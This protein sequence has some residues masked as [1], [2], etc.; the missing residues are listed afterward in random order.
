MGEEHD[1]DVDSLWK[2]VWVALLVCSERIIWKIGVIKM[3]LVW[4]LQMIKG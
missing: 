1:V 2:N 3:D 4:F